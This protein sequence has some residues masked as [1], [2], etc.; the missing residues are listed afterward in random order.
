M[1]EILYTGRNNKDLPAPVQEVEDPAEISVY[2]MTCTC[3][4]KSLSKS[5]RFPSL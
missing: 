2:S 4:T 5:K 1:K 3:D